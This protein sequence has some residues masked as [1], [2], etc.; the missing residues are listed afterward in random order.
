MIQ[1]KYQAEK[2]CLVVIHSHGQQLE[3]LEKSQRQRTKL[4]NKTDGLNNV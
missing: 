2:N 4:D 1:T 3:V